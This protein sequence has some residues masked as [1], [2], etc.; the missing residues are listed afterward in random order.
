M[1]YDDKTSVT[2]G[3]KGSV[4]VYSNTTHMKR[5]YRYATNTDTSPELVSYYGVLYW[6]ISIILQSFEKGNLLLNAWLAST[7]RITITNTD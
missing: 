1:T 5:K 4:L 6:R 2:K 7:S 3:T